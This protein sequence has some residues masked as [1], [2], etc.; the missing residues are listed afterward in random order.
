VEVASEV[1]ELQDLRQLAGDSRLDLSAIL[2][3]VGSM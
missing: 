1:L 2:P 3:G